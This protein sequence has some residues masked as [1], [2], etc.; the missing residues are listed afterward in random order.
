ALPGDLPTPNTVLTGAVAGTG[1]AN[2]NGLIEG[3]V[4]GAGVATGG[5]SEVA[6]APNQLF[7][8]GM[9]GKRGTVATQYIQ[10]Q[11]GPVQMRSNIAG[12]TNAAYLAAFPAVRN[13]I[14]LYNLPCEVVSEVD[15][16]LDDGGFQTGRSQASVAA[17][18]AG[19]TV[20]RYWVPL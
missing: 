12:A 16:A 7:I 14:I 20:A 6:Q 10:S 5:T 17:C 18:T 19:G 15:A 13:V 4:T 1:G 11:F 9:I 2:G 8:A 3:A